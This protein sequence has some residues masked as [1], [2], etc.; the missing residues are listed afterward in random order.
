MWRSTAFWPYGYWREMSIT[1]TPQVRFLFTNSLTLGD[2]M[3]IFSVSF[4]FE[5]HFVIFHEIYSW[6][7]HMKLPMKAIH[8]VVTFGS[9]NYLLHK[10]LPAPMVTQICVA[11][12]GIRYWIY[13]N[14]R[15]L[16]LML[17][18]EICRFYSNQGCIQYFSESRKFNPESNQQEILSKIHT[19]NIGWWL[20]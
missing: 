14:K 19:F 5:N 13:L 18:L 15:R 12:P 1:L 7:I 6:V 3:M 11:I 16:K 4:D 10:S 8:R 9:D 17:M 20:S 2:E